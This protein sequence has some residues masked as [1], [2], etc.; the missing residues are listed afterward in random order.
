MKDA[1]VLISAVSVVAS[2]YSFPLDIITLPI[3]LLLSLLI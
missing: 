1:F 2:V 3:R